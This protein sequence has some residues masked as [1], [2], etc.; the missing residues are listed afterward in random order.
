MFL[1]NF[2]QTL[3]KYV[4]LVPELGFSKNLDFLR[5]CEIF[6]EKIRILGQKTLYTFRKMAI[7]SE[8]GKQSTRS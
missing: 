6:F 2:L 3:S 4:D 8:I 5:S 1:P 7:K